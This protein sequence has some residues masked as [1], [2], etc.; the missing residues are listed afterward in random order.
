MK[1]LK[2][3]LPGLLLVGLL[4]NSVKADH[5]LGLAYLYGYGAMTQIGP[6]A[7]V[8][9]PPYFS[10]HPPVYYGRRYTRPYGVSPFASWPQ[11]NATPSYAPQPHVQRNQVISNPHYS[12]CGG[13]PCAPAVVKVEEKRAEPL[14]IE[15][16]YFNP[17]SN[18]IR[19]TG[20]SS[21]D[22]TDNRY[23]R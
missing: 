11:L 5:G 8:P 19:Y 17:S 6:R 7:Y 14:V 10:L 13:A 4:A 12:P 15:N 9:P 16:P 22:A 2:T 23:N 18:V 20:T 3:L 1:T 21:V